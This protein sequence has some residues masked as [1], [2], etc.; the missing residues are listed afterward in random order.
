MGFG[1]E[2]RSTKSNDILATYSAGGPASVMNSNNVAEYKALRWILEWLIDNK[3]TDIPITIIGDSMLVVKQMSGQWRIKNGLYVNEAL[4]CK[5]LLRSFSRC[6]VH[7]VCR[8][9]NTRADELS[10]MGIALARG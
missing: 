10:K 9:K 4:I 5:R 6:V 8:E 2:I 1:A 7:W 3:M